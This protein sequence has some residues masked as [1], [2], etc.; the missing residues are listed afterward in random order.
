MAL[1]GVVGALVVSGGE[2]Y[3]S[4]E[5][6]DGGPNAAKLYKAAVGSATWTRSTAWSRRTT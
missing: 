3:V 6:L 4:I 2:A 5:R 1:S